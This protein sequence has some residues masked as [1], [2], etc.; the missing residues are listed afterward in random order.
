MIEVRVRVSV[1]NREA[2]FGIGNEAEKGYVG[3]ENV[4]MGTVGMGTVGGGGVEWNGGGMGIDRMEVAN[5]CYD[6]IQYS[7]ARGGGK[8]G[9]GG[10]ALPEGDIEMWGYGDME[11]WVLVGWLGIAYW[12]LDSFVVVGWMAGLLS[13]TLLQCANLQFCII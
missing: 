8:I 3:M 4:G 7:T 5:L 10:K 12:L 2:G 11:I 6:T 9:I 13:C 1:V